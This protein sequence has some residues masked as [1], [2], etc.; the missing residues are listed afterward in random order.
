MLRMELSKKVIGILSSL[1]EDLKMESNDDEYG[2][3]VTA[4]DM[5]IEVHVSAWCRVKL[6]FHHFQLVPLLMRI[7][8]RSYYKVTL[9]T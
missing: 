4:D 3:D 8:M 1:L 6:L 5:N 9:P 2:A 7:F